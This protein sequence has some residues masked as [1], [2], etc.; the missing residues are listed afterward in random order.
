MLKTLDTWIDEIP[1]LSTPQ[2]YGNKAFKLWIERLESVSGMFYTY[3][4]L[5]SFKLCMQN[6]GSLLQNILPDSR[7]PAIKELSAYLVISFG[8]GT[9][10]DYGSGHELCFV[11]FLCCL[12]ILGVIEGKK[13]A[14]A[15]GCKIFT[16]YL[17]LVRRLQKEYSLEPAGSH[18]VWGLD[19]YQFLV[20]SASLLLLH[21]LTHLIISSHFT[22]E[23]H[24]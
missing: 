24:S 20:S 13:D 23:L 3:L 18:G 10:L 11:A 14:Q 16:A 22:L 9:R 4:H 15:I 5:N 6:V 19:D 7:F 17:G 1:P 21:Y 2:R 8:H 12:E